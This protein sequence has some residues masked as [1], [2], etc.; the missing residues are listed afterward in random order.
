MMG[1]LDLDPHALEELDAIEVPLNLEVPRGT[2][3][4]QPP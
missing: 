1:L 4:A 3:P 2:S